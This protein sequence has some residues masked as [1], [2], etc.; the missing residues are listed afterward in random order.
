VIISTIGFSR[1]RIN[2]RMIAAKA[3]IANATLPTMNGDDFRDI[4]GLKLDVW[5]AV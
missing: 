4:P 1:S 3:L 5:P 2:D